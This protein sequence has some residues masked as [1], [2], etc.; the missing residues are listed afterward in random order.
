MTV[1]RRIPVSGFADVSVKVARRLRP[2]V[3]RS[4]GASAAQFLGEPLRVSSKR[5]VRCVGC[6]PSVA[7][8]SRVEFEFELSDVELRRVALRSAHTPGSMLPRVLR[9]LR[10][11]ARSKTSERIA[12]R[13]S[14]ILARAAAREVSVVASSP[15]S[16]VSRVASRSGASRSNPHPALLFVPGPASVQ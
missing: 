6:V 16:V 14:D 10:R 9:E 13:L 3:Q 4:P 15:S 8:Q 7:S 2:S 1:E 12:G 11:A 5:S